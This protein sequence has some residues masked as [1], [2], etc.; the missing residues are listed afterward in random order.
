MRKTATVFFDGMVLRPEGPLE[1]E[2]NRRYVIT[3]AEV[4]PTT[5]AENAWDVLE[6]LAGTIEA[7]PDWAENHDHSIRNAVR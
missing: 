7:P 5:K 1:M 6:R 3:F 2:P 4:Q